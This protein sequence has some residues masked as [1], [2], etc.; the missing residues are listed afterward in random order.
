M[1]KYCLFYGSLKQGKRNFNRFGGQN[2]I[3][4][5]ELDGYEMYDFKY[6]P[7]ICGGNGKI[8]VELHSVELDSFENIR[9][10]ELGAG[11]K[12]KLLTVDNINATLFVM[13]KYQ[14]KRFPRVENGNW[15]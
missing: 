3:K 10:M 8:T 13:D 2:Y 7:G 11:Y 12:E 1:N 4:T 9:G 5:L 14:V 15:E 6:Y